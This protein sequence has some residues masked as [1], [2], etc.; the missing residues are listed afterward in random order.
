MKP[1]IDPA[2]FPFFYGW[3]VLGAGTLGI[4]MS[5]PGQTVGV[6]VFTDPLIA[7]LGLGRS[8]L[9][10]GYLVGTLASALL[11]SFAGR[12]YDRYGA[13][14]V[15]TCAAAGLAATLVYLSF[16][17]RISGALA[18]GAP[19]PMRAA[20]SFT[21]ITLGFFLVRFTGQGVLT[22]ASR[23]MVL[24]WFEVRRGVANAIMGVAVSFG[25]AYAPRV[26]ESVLSENSW[27]GA[28]RI[29]AL[30]L[31]G[32]AVVAAIVFRD[33]PEAH[34]LVPDG[35]PVKSS[36]KHHAELAP[37]ADFTLR[38]ARNTFSFWVFALALFMGGLVMTAYTFHIVSIFQDGFGESDASRTLALSLFLP[39]SVIAVGF[40]FVGS[41]LSNYIKL[42]YFCMLQLAGIVA[43]CAGM[44]FLGPG[45][46]TV[47]VV[48]GHGISQG[49][50]GITSAITW[51]RFYGRKH[52]GAVS[53]LAA[54]LTV[55][56]SAVGPFMFSFGRDLTSSYATAAVV[57]GVISLSLLVGSFWAERPVHPSAVPSV[58]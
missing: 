9:S 20:L 15:A 41:W 18:G 2:R 1:L 33:T 27:E 31:G 45:A 12:L 17:A 4:L 7:A 51:P 58:V 50:F 3:V 11:L 10:L 54:A 35:G 39:A 42:K 46:P 43:L 24:E 53:G 5:A 13:R 56:G 36:T 16:S 40:Q 23:N 8:A 52:L 49:I 21:V 25:F 14:L 6:S 44:V 47:I 32:F 19:E 30:V 26:F 22:L 28:W 48:A 34:G 29:L 57:C 55:A 37:A 38:E